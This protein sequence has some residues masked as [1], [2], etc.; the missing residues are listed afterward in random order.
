MNQNSTSL[1]VVNSQNI[2]LSMLIKIKDFDWSKYLTYSKIIYNVAIGFVAYLFG[3][4]FL[5]S[6]AIQFI[7]ECFINWEWGRNFT[8]TKLGRDLKNHHWQETLADNI[9]F[10]LGWIFCY[11]FRYK[12]I[13]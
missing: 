4:N 8:E 9:L 5:T 2:F 11:I 7:W 6:L 13:L 10:T 3:A 1:N 12:M